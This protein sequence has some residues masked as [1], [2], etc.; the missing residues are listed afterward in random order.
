MKIPKSLGFFQLSLNIS[1][2]KKKETDKKEMITSIEYKE[3]IYKQYLEVFSSELIDYATQFLLD[4]LEVKKTDE[5]ILDLASG[6]K[7]FLK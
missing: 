2:S 6:N 7:I 5:C 3:S 4:H 1:R